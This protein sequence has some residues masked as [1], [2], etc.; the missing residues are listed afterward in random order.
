MTHSTVLFAYNKSVSAFTI[1]SCVTRHVLRTSTFFS[2]TSVDM[3]CKEE[4]MPFYCLGVNV[5]KQIGGQTHLK[6]IL[7]DNE[8]EKVVMGFSES[9]RGISSQDGKIVLSKYGKKINN[10]IETRLKGLIERVKEDGKDFINKFLEC[11]KDAVKTDSGMVYCCRHEGKGIKPKVK[12]TVEVHYHGTLMDGTVFDSS[13]QSGRTVSFPLGGVIKGWQEGL[14]MMNNGGKATLIIPSDLA[15]GDYGSGGTVPP[16]A[17]LKF[18]I[19][20]FT[21]S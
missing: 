7:N 13:V 2:K 6:S 8:I 3:P 18:E 11:N 21:V 16:G 5:A 14:P 15:Y 10:I 1:R 19:E 17:T 12:N 4:E 20:M 9:L